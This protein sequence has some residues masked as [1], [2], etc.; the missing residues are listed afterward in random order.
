MNARQSGRAGFVPRSW[1]EGLWGTLGEQ[2]E[3]GAES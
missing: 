1:L 3:G 2:V